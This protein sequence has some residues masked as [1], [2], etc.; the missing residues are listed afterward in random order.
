MRKV[1]R[2]NEC[3]KRDR[4]NLFSYE[5]GERWKTTRERE[6]N[7]HNALT[8]TIQNKKENIVAAHTNTHTHTRTHAHTHTLKHTRP[9]L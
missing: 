5:G 1:L 7:V 8:K 9:F 2:R 3:K 4:K 6:E